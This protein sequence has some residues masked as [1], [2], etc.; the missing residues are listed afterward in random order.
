MGEG[1]KGQ[2]YIYNPKTDRGCGFAESNMKQDLWRSIGEIHVFQLCR[3][4]GL[5]LLQF[6]ANKPCR[7]L[8]AVQK[9]VDFKINSLGVLVKFTSFVC[10]IMHFLCAL[11]SER[12]GIIHAFT[13]IVWEAC[14]C[15]SSFRTAS[16]IDGLLCNVFVKCGWFAA[17]FVFGSGAVVTANTEFENKFCLMGPLCTFFLQCVRVCVHE[18]VIMIF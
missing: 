16:I 18:Q 10:Q 6:T 14:L 1:C 2:T 4:F 5:E 3:E 15:P 17:P 9:R 11:S 7:F 13:R 12:C 8:R